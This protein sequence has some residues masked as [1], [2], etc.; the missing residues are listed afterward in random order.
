MIEK[1]SIDEF[2]RR[3]VREFHPERIILFG[4]SALGKAMADSDVDLL[5]IM[6]TGGSGLR[7]AA[8]ILEK[9][10]T[11]IPVDLVVRDPSD[12]R[13]RLEANDYFL[14]EIIDKGQVLYES[15][16]A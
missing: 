3:I 16:D 15:T 5:I 10:S 13:R 6:P 12:V 4:S 14:R 1:E 9:I 2:T 11:R 7:K 8:E